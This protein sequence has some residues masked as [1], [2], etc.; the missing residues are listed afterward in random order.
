M[1]FAALVARPELKVIVPMSGVLHDAPGYGWRSLGAPG[2]ESDCAH[3][4]R[5]ARRSGL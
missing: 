4:R 2:A 3:E 1:A 5:V